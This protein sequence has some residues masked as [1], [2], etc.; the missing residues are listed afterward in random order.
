MPSGLDP[1][2]SIHGLNSRVA[3]PAKAESIGAEVN[4]PRVERIV[5]TLLALAGMIRPP[6]THR[7]P[8]PP[9]RLLLAG[10]TRRVV[11]HALGVPRPSRGDNPPL[12]CPGGRSSR[13]LRRCP[14]SSAV[15]MR[16][17]ARSPAVTVRPSGLPAVV[18]AGV[19]AS[20]AAPPWLWDRGGDG[21]LRR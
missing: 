4:S 7:L 15:G 14:T 3:H 11:G 19:R 10:V 2:E 12:A 18:D 16:G 5:N 6:S 13:S 21:G 1:S 20:R 9:V 17:R 8:P